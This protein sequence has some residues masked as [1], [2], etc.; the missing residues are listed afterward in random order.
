MNAAK[1]QQIIM[2]LI[3][4][5]A[6]F[7]T[8]SSVLVSVDN[9]FYSSDLRFHWQKPLEKLTGS[10]VASTSLSIDLPPRLLR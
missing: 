4:G 6:A 9:E 2:F 3:S 7:G 5:A 8:L 1:S 10:F